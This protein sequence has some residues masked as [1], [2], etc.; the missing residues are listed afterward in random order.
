VFAAR[1]G[2]PFT[3]AYG[4]KAA[5]PGALPAASV[6]PRRADGEL[7][8]VKLAGLGPI[9]QTRKPAVSL[10]EHEDAKKWLLW[11]ALLAGVL[12]LTWM[13]LRLLRELGS[14]AVK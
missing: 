1:G 4:D 9:A 5:K 3:L 6:M 8:P 13:A 7:P 10:F 14:S 12:V 11:F 2:A